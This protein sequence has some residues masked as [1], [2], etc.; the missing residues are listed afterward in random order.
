MYGRRRKG[1][2]YGRNSIG[3]NAIG[4]T[5]PALRHVTKSVK[6]TEYKI[7]L[8]PPC[9]TKTE[10]I[11][12][13]ETPAPEEIKEENNKSLGVSLGN[14]AVSVGVNG[15]SGKTTTKKFTTNTRTS[16]RKR[17]PIDYT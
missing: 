13:V 5:P 6:E 8:N 7:K 12:E 10:K 14:P 3:T 2:G 9:L 15:S 16:K 17:D 1:S 4:N 11:K